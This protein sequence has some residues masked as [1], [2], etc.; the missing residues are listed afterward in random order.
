MYQPELL[1]SL[2][3]YCMDPSLIHYMDEFHLTQL[4]KDWRSEYPETLQLT[5][6]TYHIKVKAKNV[7]KIFC[8]MLFWSMKF[9]C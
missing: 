4:D 3:E 9:R 1:L 5:D 7:G 2:A 6:K 8:M